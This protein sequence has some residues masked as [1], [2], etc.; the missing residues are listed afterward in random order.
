MKFAAADG[1]SS[2]P[3]DM[4]AKK[5]TNDTDLQLT[6]KKRKWTDPN[7]LKVLTVSHFV[8]LNVFLD[9]FCKLYCVS[10]LT[11]TQQQNLLTEFKHLVVV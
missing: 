1:L 10:C 5:E 11:N 6:F 2:Y 9:V 7:Q 8:E 4:E 3:N